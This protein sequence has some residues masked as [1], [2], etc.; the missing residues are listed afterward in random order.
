MK[1]LFK[2]FFVTAICLFFSPFIF[3]QA[4]TLANADVTQFA[5]TIPVNK[6]ILLVTNTPSNFDTSTT[7]ILQL[8]KAGVPDTVIDAMRAKA[9]APAAKSVVQNASASSTLPQTADRDTELIQSDARGGVY[10][11]DASN[12]SHKLRMER[13]LMA[14][15]EGKKALL[16][17]MGVGMLKKSAIKMYVKGE[18]SN[19]QMKD[20]NI[21]LFLKNVPATE[22]SEIK[23]V[24]L[25]LE[26]DKRIVSVA[27]AYFLPA[28]STAKEKEVEVPVEQVGSTDNFRITPPAALEPGH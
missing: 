6:L 25:T 27:K 11:I 18:N 17:V 3:G 23:L 20:G 4:S 1:K 14:T 2:L 8:A 9:I 5:K 10:L 24:R 16:N 28:L 26:K 7:A 15:N 22:Q 13:Q 19:V 12:I 21:H